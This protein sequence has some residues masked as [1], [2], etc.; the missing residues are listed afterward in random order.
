VKTTL[1]TKTVIN[2][3]I[4]QKTPATVLRIYLN[5]I[6]IIRY[7]AIHR[8]RWIIFAGSIY[9]RDRSAPQL[10]ADFDGQSYRIK[11]SLMKNYT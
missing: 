10:S 5:Y 11:N 3:F 6:P 1:K 4:K 9:T 2:I 7:Q 8:L